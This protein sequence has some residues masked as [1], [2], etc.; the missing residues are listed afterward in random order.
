[1][2]DAREGIAIASL[3]IY[4]PALLTTI[5][6]LIRQGHA[7]QLGWIYLLIFSFIRIA[8]SI[9]ELLHK[10]TPSNTSYTEWSLI[11]QSVGLSPLLLASLGILKRVIDFTSTHVRSSPDSQSNIIVNHLSMKFGIIAKFAGKASADARRSRLIQLLQIPTTIALILCI[12]G[13]MDEA[14]T[15]ST[16]ASDIAEG[17]TDT[18]WGI[19]IFIVIYVILCILAFISMFEVHKTARGEKRLLVAVVIALPMIG[20]RLLWSVLCA[21]KGG[22][23][24]NIQDGSAVVQICMAN[25][26]EVIVVLMYV[27]VGL[28]VQKYDD[29]VLERNRLTQVNQESLERRQRREYAKRQAWAEANENAWTER[30]Q[31]AYR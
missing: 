9:L 5:L 4:I 23:I 15:S 27:L 31:G 13:G 6:L 21:F 11:L 12:V 17:K 18:K 19:G 14:S 8:G 29:V 10:S 1:M 26:E 28:T 2:T 20:S 22:D 16:S 25:A 3:I 24:F 7:R 30:L